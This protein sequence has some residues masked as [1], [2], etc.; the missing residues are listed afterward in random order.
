M[1]YLMYAFLWVI[2]GRLNFICR[3]FGTPCMFHLHR[4]VC[5]YTPEFYMPTFRNTLFHLHTRVGVSTHTYLPLKMEHPECSETS[6]YTIQTPGN[7]REESIQH[8]EHGESLK[9][10]KSYL[11]AVP[12]AEPHSWAAALANTGTK[13][14]S[15][16]TVRPSRPP[17]SATT[18]KF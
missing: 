18:T 1:S 16:H 15:W 6:A 4:Q 13:P 12:S 10:R 9:S 14:S 8:W 11:F 2:P 5:V 17:T 7:Y 3:R